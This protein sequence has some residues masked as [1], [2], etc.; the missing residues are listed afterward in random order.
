MPCALILSQS[1]AVLALA[2]AES[3]PSQAYAAANDAALTA[4]FDA[5]ASTLTQVRVAQ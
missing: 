3:F 2:V 4:A 1:S 5:I